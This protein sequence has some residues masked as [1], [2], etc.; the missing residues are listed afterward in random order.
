MTCPLSHYYQHRFDVSHYCCWLTAKK[1]TNKLT[2]KTIGECRV[3]I[4]RILLTRYLDY[5]NNNNSD[6]KQTSTSTYIPQQ[7]INTCH[8][9]TVNLYVIEKMCARAREN[10]RRS[11]GH[12][13]CF[14]CLHP[15][16]SRG[17]VSM[18]TLLFLSSSFVKR[19]IRDYV[20]M[21]ITRHYLC[22]CARV[23]VCWKQCDLIR[24]YS[25]Y[26]V[27]TSKEE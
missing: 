22:G 21:R 19:T 2:S 18:A 11:V 15:Y 16:N 3:V 10:I 17:E 4:T 7:L 24:P 12:I 27:Q 1:E 26:S 25:A 23:Y 14:C 6:T 9:T 13:C 20:F 8:S 5:K